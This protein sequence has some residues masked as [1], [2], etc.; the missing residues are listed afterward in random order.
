MSTLSFEGEVARNN[1]LSEDD[2]I[3][4]VSLKSTQSRPAAQ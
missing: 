3:A 2:C 4:L 1:Q